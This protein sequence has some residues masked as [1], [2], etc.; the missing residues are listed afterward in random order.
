MRVRPEA[1]LLAVLLV[2]CGGV[3]PDPVPQKPAT[4][5]LPGGARTVVARFDDAVVYAGATHFF[6]TLPGGERIR[7][8][9]SNDP[10]APRVDN[11]VTLLDPHPDEGPPGPNA[12]LLGRSFEIVY[13]Y[14]GRVVGVYEAHD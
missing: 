6:F 12:A 13:D 4:H 3:A 7:I 10:G 8:I 2:A 11:S 5:E 9:E 14:S 1:A